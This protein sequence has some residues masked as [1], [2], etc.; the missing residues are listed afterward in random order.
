MSEEIIIFD[1]WG[2]NR[3]GDPVRLET[4]IAQIH[5]HYIDNRALTHIRRWRKK[6]RD[7]AVN[8]IRMDDER[9]PIWK[10]YRDSDLYL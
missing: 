10:T 5:R 8:V 6:G 7:V 3:E 2:Y 9:L 4:K 1:I